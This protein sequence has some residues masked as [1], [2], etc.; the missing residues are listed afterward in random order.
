MTPGYINRSPGNKNYLL[1]NNNNVFIVNY[2]CSKNGNNSLVIKKITFYV[3]HNNTKIKYT[4]YFL[5]S[6]YFSIDNLVV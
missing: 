2:L 4:L 1:F 3:S 6:T 5:Q